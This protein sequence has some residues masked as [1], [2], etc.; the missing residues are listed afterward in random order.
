MGV[1]RLHHLLIDD[2]IEGITQNNA[3]A[4]GS[5]VSPLPIFLV[6]LNIKWMAKRFTWVFLTHL[7]K[8]ST[9]GAAVV[10]YFL[11]TVGVEF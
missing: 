1:L 11:L 5:Q 9:R 7:K 3:R 4:F 2:F 10:R 8:F 6:N